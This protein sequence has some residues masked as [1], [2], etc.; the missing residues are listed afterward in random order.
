MSFWTFGR[1]LFVFGGFRK[2][3]KAIRG[4]VLQIDLVGDNSVKPIKITGLGPRES[5]TTTVL[6]E[7]SCS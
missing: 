6:K 4:P 2:G 5:H 1:R 7:D 3:Y